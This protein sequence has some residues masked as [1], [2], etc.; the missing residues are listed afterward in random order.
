LIQS[1][2]N[3]HLL[4]TGAGF[5]APINPG[6]TPTQPANATGNQITEANRQ[7][8]VDQ[9]KYSIY[10]AVKRNLK[11]QLT[12]AIDSLFIDKLRDHTMGFA[13]ASTLQ[14]LSHLH[15]TYGAVQ[16]DQLEANAMQLGCQWDPSD[17]IE[18]V[19]Q[20]AQ[21]CRRFSSS[22]FDPISES[23]AVR[24]TVS[25]FERSVESLPTPSTIGAND[26]T[27]NGLGLISRPTLH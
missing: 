23:T 5:E 25:M 18:T 26:R 1:P 6:L 22:G 17:P 19:W 4:L 9:S 16:S 2:A 7:Y 12:S 24:K 11:T 27:P 14:L 10:L 13:N 15:T 20:N 3:Y 21:E 8:R